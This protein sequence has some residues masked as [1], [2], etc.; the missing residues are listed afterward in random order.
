ME[1]LLSG[2]VQSLTKEL[3]QLGGGLPLDLQ[4]HRSQP[5]PLFQHLLHMGPEILAY[6]VVLI[7][8]ANIG[9]AGH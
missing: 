6:V 1:H 3:L 2:Q 7:L 8:R 5:G 9:V 4:T